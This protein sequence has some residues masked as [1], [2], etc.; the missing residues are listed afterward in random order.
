MYHIVAADSR[1][2]RTGNF[3]E[4]V[5]RYEPLQKPAAISTKEDRLFYW[6]SKGA[7]PTDTV[8]SLLRRSGAWMKWSMT[9]KGMA[10]AT[11]ATEME[12]WQLLQTVKHQR[13]E[14]RKAQ[15][16]AVKRQAKKAEAPAATPA[17]VESAPQ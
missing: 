13:K 1:S 2:A 14:E 11:I 17:A 4:I 9:K 12:K 10:E 7:L 15:R 5:G 6:L 3:L 16:L 8:R